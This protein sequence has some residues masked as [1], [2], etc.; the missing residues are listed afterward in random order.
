VSLL[1]LFSGDT[2]GLVEFPMVYSRSTG[3][4]LDEN[5]VAI[6]DEL[7]DVIIV[8]DGGIFPFGILQNV[9]VVFPLMSLSPTIFEFE[10]TQPAQVTVTFDLVTSTQTIFEFAVSQIGTSTVEFPLVTM[11]VTIFPFDVSIAGTQTMGFPLVTAE[12]TIFDFSV[13]ASSVIGFELVTAEFTI[14]PFTVVSGLGPYLFEPPHDEN[15]P[16]KLSEY[17]RR[18]QGVS[19]VANDLAGRYGAPRSYSVLKLNGVYEIIQGPTMDQDN[20]ATEYYAGGHIHEVTST[21]AAALEAAGF[22]VVGFS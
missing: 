8:D 20:A 13:V 4:L 6:L 16:R 19:R 1:L 5:G 15:G 2:P 22:D 17:G 7:G 14:F 3:V 21:V 9:T 18:R 11:P 12:F 10:V